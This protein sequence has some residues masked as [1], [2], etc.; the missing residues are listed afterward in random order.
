M[1]PR[2]LLNRIAVALIAATLALGLL[3]V[4]ALAADYD[5]A[6]AFDTD[7]TEEE[8]AASVSSML[9]AGE[10]VEGEA[11]VCS[12][13][14]SSGVRL[15][16]TKDVA[17]DD[18][19]ARAEQLSTVTKSQY[20]EAIGESVPE[21][22]GT[23]LLRAP[24]AAETVAIQ[25]VHVDGMSTEE[26]L[27]ALLHD[28]RV[29]SAEPNYIL[30]F[31]EETDD[32]QPVETPETEDG[33][34]PVAEE[35]V[36]D[37]PTDETEPEDEAMPDTDDGPV[38]IATDEAD[39]VVPATEEAETPT[40]SEQTQA[41]PQT[42]ATYDLT[43]Y[44]WFSVGA[45]NTVPTYTDATN[46]GVSAPNWNEPGTENASG[47]VVI[48][49]SGV[50]Y[51]HPDLEDVMYH[52]TAEQQAALGCG[53]FGYASLRED[54]TDPMDG[55]GHG[56]HCAGIVA[57]KWND[58][59]VSG[60]ANGVKIIAVS[61][62]R[63]IDD[64]TFNYESIIKGYDFI[65][66][67]A[68]SGIDIRAINRSIAA[69]TINIANEVMVTAAGELGI[70]TCIATGNMSV[71]TDSAAADVAMNQPNPYIVRVNASKLQDDYAWFSNYGTYTTDVFAP[72]VAILSTIPSTEESY[73]RYFPQA[74]NDPLYLLTEFDTVPDISTNDNL[75]LSDFRLGN[76]SVDGDGICLAAD[77]TIQGEYGNAVYVDVPIG[78][79]DKADLQDIS[80]ALHI[81]NTETRT[82]GFGI[83]MDDGTYL[84]E[85]DEKLVNETSS[86]A[87]GGWCFAST[88][89]YD[90]SLI[91]NEFQY[92]T[93]SKGN[94]CIRLVIYLSISQRNAE[95]EEAFDRTVHIDQIAI[96]KRGNSG[97]LPYMYMNGTSMAAP[98]VTGCAAIVSSMLPESLSPSERAAQTVDILKGAVH[99]TSGYQGYCKQNGQ[100]DLGIL[101]DTSKYAPVLKS[102]TAEDGKLVLSGAYFGSTGTLLVEGT[103]IRTETWS[104]DTITATWPKGLESGLI[105]LSVTNAANKTAIQAFIVEAPASA[106]DSAELYE[107][108]LAS[109]TLYDEEASI[110]DT[111]Q[112]LA[113][114]EDGVLFAA[115]PDGVG[116]L[117]AAVYRLLRSDDKGSSWET[118]DL[119]Q[120]LKYVSLAVSD[121]VVFVFGSTPADD[122]S[123]FQYWYLYVMDIETET[124]KELKSYEHFGDEIYDKGS[125][126]NAAG[127]LYYVDHWTGGSEYGMG[128]RV[129][130]RRFADDFSLTD[131]QV[132]THE[133]TEYGFY[134]MPMVSAYGNSIYVSQLDKETYGED[135]SLLRGLERADISEDGSMT[136]TDLSD[137]VVG[138]ECK[139]EN[140][141][142]VASD[143]GIF[144]VGQ[145]LDLLRTEDS[146][147]TDTFFLGKG[148]TS[149]E[150]YAKRLSYAPLYSPK[151]ICVDGWLYVYATS[152]YEALP[153]F[154]RATKLAEAKTG[155][156]QED[157]S[158]HYY[159]DDGVML[160]EG[161]AEYDGSYY[162]L[163]ADGFV[164]KDGWAAYEGQYYYIR[165]YSPMK[166]G[167]VAY[168]STYCYIKDYT[169][170]EEG[171]VSYN[172]N[173]Y[174][175]KD[176]VPMKEGWAT[177]QGKY[178]YI[179]NYVPMR[180][181]WVSYGGS[182]YYIRSY[183][184][185]VNTWVSYGGKWYHFD[186]SGVC[187]RVA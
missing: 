150:P 155:W 148:A 49:D 73:S 83:L 170:M 27:T 118:I 41:N 75:E 163:D 145:G 46:P 64:N 74:D 55:L 129:R 19:L 89:I 45:E 132:F 182:Y 94:T 4:P 127:N 113:A 165:N 35:D 1:K 93:D 59:G 85:F 175:I 156:Q 39:P 124:F 115:V 110:L 81:P 108:D 158:W 146:P 47:V 96:G 54:P 180:E 16:A 79:V 12:L 185:V 162:Y 31:T 126:V 63:A 133:Y 130:I 28:S 147:T 50:D 40:T 186:G 171:W 58:Y 122:D 5:E 120:G 172:G 9:A 138:L 112:A 137:A 65:I 173:Y 33:T 105:H 159:T 140:I 152:K 88:H 34:E 10:Y 18:L 72:G 141:C 84:G 178:Y 17:S 53:E 38:A 100:V 62:S 48:L 90:P 70:V 98:V 23:I 60:I 181:G 20:A 144:L 117:G 21:P 187:D 103:A 71:D 37:V 161:F 42:S 176:Y 109:I 26:L 15:M 57:A 25:L 157:G 104:D 43:P 149:F 102:A 119:P 111:P 14:T 107:R 164:Q 7:R 69:P 167:W 87:I 92:V 66:R 77:A 91:E 97:F 3:L 184:P 177:Y 134:D 121:G 32:G 142:M 8:I 29:L 183:N 99:Q 67:A 44:Q 86:N 143:E 82:I 123:N 151:G 125:I 36:V 135:P 52:F 51:T 101:G 136:F 154:G 13:N 6:T 174:Y 2:R 56:T 78:V 131:P 168:G 61:V 22:S 166:E 24:K 169:A 11:I 114:T 139:R 68:K 80:I 106:V 128:S 116:H 95:T 160:T 30:G 153:Q 179:R 76:I